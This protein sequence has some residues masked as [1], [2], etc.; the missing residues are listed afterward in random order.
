[1]EQ[2]GGSEFRDKW[3]P[4]ILAEREKNKI[5]HYLITALQFVKEKDSALILGDA[6]LIQT[7]YLIEEAGFKQVIDV[8]SSPSILD[9]GILTDNQDGFVTRIISTFEEYNPPINSFDF[10]YGK[11]IAFVKK[12]D[13]EKVLNQICLSLKQNGIF[14]AVWGL[15]GD[16]FRPKL[17]QQTLERIYNNAGFEIIK[18]DFEQAEKRGLI[19]MGTVH[20]I[21]IIAKR[22][23]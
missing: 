6:S 23:S 8:D 15:S 9:N 19:T 1:M 3:R 14:S 12:S 11:S 2:N 18:K 16:S 20:T 22:I 10:V 21:H 13:L 4:A 7:K 17:D 5:H